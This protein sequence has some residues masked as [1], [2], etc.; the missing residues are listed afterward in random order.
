MKQNISGPMA[1]SII[2]VVVL[3]LGVGL[4]R[5]FFYEKKITAEE[6]RANMQKAQQQMQ[7]R[8]NR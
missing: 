4:Y 1:V 5:V 2:V 7:Q 8:Y 3:L 6:T